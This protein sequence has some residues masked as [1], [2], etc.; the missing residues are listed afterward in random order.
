MFFYLVSSGSGGRFNV[1]LSDT[2]AKLIT[3]YNAIRDNPKGVIEHL[4]KDEY[5]YK[6]HSYS[7]QEYH[8]YRLRD[9]WNIDMKSS[10]DIEIASLLIT[11]NKTCHRGLYRENNGKFNTPW[12]RDPDATICDRNNIENV[13]N[14]LRYSRATIYTSD[15]K[16]ATENAQRGDFVYLDPPYD[17]VSYTSNFT[18]YTTDGFGRED[19]EQLASVFRKLSDRGCFVLLSNSDTPFIRELYSGFVIREV[20]AQRAINIKVSKRTGKELLISNYS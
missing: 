10:S 15:Y 13:S 16:D 12:G 17:P 9:V 8:Y 4:Q 20:E 18:A 5:E 2:N 6:A 7:E 3:A 19:Q 1:Y 14:V 11:L